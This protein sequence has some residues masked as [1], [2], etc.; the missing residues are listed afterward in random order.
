MNEF[1]ALYTYVCIFH[2]I[3]SSIPCS[4]Y[5]TKFPSDSIWQQKSKIHFFLDVLP[6]RRRK[7]WHFHFCGANTYDVGTLDDMYTH[8]PTTYIRYIYRGEYSMGAWH[9]IPRQFMRSFQQL[10]GLVI[11]R[12]M[13]LAYEHYER[14]TVEQT[15]TSRVIVVNTYIH[16]YS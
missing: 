3:L 13:V 6:L 7:T 10:H 15:Q 2:L 5:Q 9:Q 4:L 16:I 8:M 14:A 12:N 11:V 1:W